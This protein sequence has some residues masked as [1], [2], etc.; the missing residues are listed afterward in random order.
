MNA[1]ATSETLIIR[2]STRSSFLLVGSFLLVVWDIHTLMRAKFVSLWILLPN[3]KGSLCFL[4]SQF[5]NS[6]A[7]QLQSVKHAVL[8]SSWVGNNK[9]EKFNIFPCGIR[10]CYYVISHA[11][12]STT[13]CSEISFTT[14]SPFVLVNKCKSKKTTAIKILI[15]CYTK[16]IKAT[17]TY[18]V[19][20]INIRWP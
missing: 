13:F 20:L 15:F 12:V 5:L 19:T 9:V 14:W 2:I 3:L 8:Q 4:H 18:R 17:C 7:S 16:S 10:N 11:S 6:T 1:K